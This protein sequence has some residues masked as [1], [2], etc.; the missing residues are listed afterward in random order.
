MWSKQEPIHLL[1]DFDD[2]LSTR[3]PS[4]YLHLEDE[5]LG[6]LGIKTEEWWQQIKDI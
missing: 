4:E 6:D 2:K 1:Q 3:H 5:K